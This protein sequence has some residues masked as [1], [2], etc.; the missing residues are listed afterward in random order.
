[1]LAINVEYNKKLPFIILANIRLIMAFFGRIRKKKRRFK[2]DRM[3]L[4]KQR[5]LFAFDISLNATGLNPNS[6]FAFLFNKNGP[7]F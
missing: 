7:S 3:R 6:F 4:N 1:M 5:V 2:R